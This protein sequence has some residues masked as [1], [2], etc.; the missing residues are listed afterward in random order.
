MNSDIPSCIFVPNPGAHRH[1]ML[2]YGSRRHSDPIMG[3]FC[4]HSYV[5]CVSSSNDKDESPSCNSKQRTTTTASMSTLAAEE[6]VLIVLP[7]NATRSQKMRRRSYQIDASRGLRWATSGSASNSS[8]CTSPPALPQRT[9]EVVGPISLADLAS[10]VQSWQERKK[11]SGSLSTPSS[12]K[13]LARVSNKEMED[14][15]MCDTECISYH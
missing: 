3:S 10:E 5:G 9:P 6:G 4:P 14:T 15:T 1:V 8:V 11:R 12:N 7:K 13:F 2:T